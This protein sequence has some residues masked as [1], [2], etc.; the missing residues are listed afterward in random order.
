MTSPSGGAFRKTEGPVATYMSTMASHSNDYY[1]RD[2]KWIDDGIQN[3]RYQMINRWD[4]DI[5]E[6][7]N[8]I[9]RYNGYC[10]GIMI[11]ELVIVG[12]I[13]VKFL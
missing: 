4:S 5:I 10:N 2:S 13:M 1:I 11:L 9:N 12:D 3:N 6:S 7:P 8:K